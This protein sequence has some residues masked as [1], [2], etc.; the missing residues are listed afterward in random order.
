MRSP[1]LSLRQSARKLGIVFA[2]FSISDSERER[3]LDECCKTGARLAMLPNFIEQIANSSSS[4]SPTSEQMRGWLE[5]VQHV[6][7][8]GCLED[9]QRKVTG[10]LEKLPEDPSL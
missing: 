1:C 4:K 9:V 10:L 2:I 7:Q 5:E 8:N 6:A 3:L